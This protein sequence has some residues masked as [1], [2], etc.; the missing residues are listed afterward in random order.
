MTKKDLVKK[1]YLKLGLP[2]EESAELLESV[3]EIIK[4]HLNREKTSK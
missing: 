2:K 3:M 1:V 4:K